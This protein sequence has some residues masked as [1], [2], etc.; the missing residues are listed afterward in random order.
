MRRSSLNM[1][2][3]IMISFRTT[4]ELNTSL[5]SLA[6]KNQSS[7]SAFIDSILQEYLE[8]QAGQESLQQDRRKFPRQH[9]AIPAIISGCNGSKKLFHASKITNLSLGGI[10]LTVPK[11][12]LTDK[13]VNDKLGEFELVFA[14]PQE[15][16]AI[17]IQCRTKRILQD[18]DSY[19]VGASFDDTDLKSYQALQGYLF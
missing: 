1:T 5:K 8:S 19:Q 2:K 13:F 12:D 15:E 4:E 7:L 3:D 10:S 18:M 14:L 16:K 9:E 11:D 17:M 6:K